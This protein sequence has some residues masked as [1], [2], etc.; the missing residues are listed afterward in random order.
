MT[1]YHRFSWSRGLCAAA[2]GCAASLV[3]MVGGMPAHSAPQLPERPPTPDPTYGLPLPRL[4]APAAPAEEAHWI[5]SDHVAGHQDVYVRGV[6]TLPRQASSAQVAITADDS[7]TLFVNGRQVDSSESQELGWKTTHLV[8]VE[9]FLRRGRNVIAIH[10]VNDGGGAAGI[11]ARLDI[12]GKPALLTGAGWK[13]FSGSPAPAGW[14]TPLFEDG[15]WVPA[16]VEAPLGGGPWGAGVDN[17]PGYHTGAWYMAHMTMQA[18]AVE[19]PSG[20]DAIQG[21]K[22]LIGSGPVHVTVAPTAGGVAEQPALLVDFGED[23]AGR[24]VI[25]G[26]SDAPSPPVSPTSITTGAPAA[27]P[28][29]PITVTTGESEEECYHAEPGLNNSGPFPLTLTGTGTA[30]TPFSAFRYALLRF[31]GGGPVTLTG[32]TLDHKYYPVAYRGS[33]SCS[34]PLLTRI[35]YIGAYTA[36]NCMQ[37]DIWDA[38]K[39]DRGLWCGDLQVTGSSINVA[40]A[41]RFLMEQSI[42]KL[43]EIA[44]AG[45]PDSALPTA[46][47]NNIPGYSAAWFCELADFYRY[48]GGDAFLQSQHEKIISLLEFQ[49]T[50]FDSRN[51]FVNPRNDWDFCDWA[52]DFVQKTPQT[53]AATDLYIIKGVREAVFLLRQLGDT[54]AADKYTAWADTLTEAARQNLADAGTGLYGDRLQTN[55]MAVYSGVA[56]PAQRAGVYEH[57]LK[58]DSPIWTAPRQF[59]NTLDSELLSPY[60]GYFVLGA[61]GEL[62]RNQDGLDLIRRYWGEMVRRGAVTWWEKFDPGFPKDFKAVLDR[63]PILSL[64]HGWSSGPTGYLTERI[65]GVRPTSGGFKTAEITPHLGDLQWAAGVVPTPHGPIRL[66]ASQQGARTVLRLTLPP[67]IDAQVGVPGTTLSLNGHSITPTSQS[68]GV[69]YLRLKSGGKYVVEGIGE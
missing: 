29:S 12:G 39:R 6:V 59:V 63:M 26:K 43:R 44:Q 32:V 30:T 57:F 68:D 54:A 22:T 47:V 36:H 2:L 40:F 15:S 28:P 34:D 55:V 8:P 62:G 50:D 13:L 56:T 23:L 61:Y 49:K 5:W 66:N 1:N 20:A 41:D 65:L 10:G 19:T 7:F 25:T 37:E 11:L 4:K 9:K 51:L 64:S 18:V 60:Y 3:M 53:R 46:E 14:N 52:P 48:E 33:F 31:T 45:R 24:L 35:W 67:G 42:R 38:P 17:W 21:A 16:T 58:S 69:S 27:A